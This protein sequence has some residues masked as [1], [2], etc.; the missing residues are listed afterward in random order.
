MKAICIW[1]YTLKSIASVK[2]VECFGF[3]D[4][5]F[6][7]ASLPFSLIQKEQYIP[8]QVCSDTQGASEW[9]YRLLSDW[10]T[11]ILELK[12]NIL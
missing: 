7:A 9:Q 10:A 11:N 1:V 4:A 6:E 5:M 3:D 12:K 2:Q 8:V